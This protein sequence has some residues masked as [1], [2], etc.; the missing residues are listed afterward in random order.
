MLSTVYRCR[1]PRC[2]DTV[3][4]LPEGTLP[5]T[6]YS[7]ETIGTALS[8]YM[9]PGASYRTTAMAIGGVEV[10]LGLTRTTLWGNVTLPSPMPS[11]VFR[12]VARFAA[13]AATWWPEIAASTQERL[14]HALTLPAHPR[15][16][17]VKARTPAKERQI[18]TA[19]FLV[20]VLYLLTGLLGEPARFWPRTLL[21][22]ERRPPCLDHTGWFA[23]PGRAPP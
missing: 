21:H 20:S 22:A 18:V 4:L 2:R 19:W 16:L 17:A 10:P 11:T 15:H 13:G 6:T 9:E 12:W 7:L 3:R 23:R 5:Q 8:T 14:S 1:C